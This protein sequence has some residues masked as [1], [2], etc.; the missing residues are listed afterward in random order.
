VLS[1]TATGTDGDG[2]TQGNE[3]NQDSWLGSACVGRP[4][5]STVKLHRPDYV[6]GSPF[7]NVT[8]RVKNL[9]TGHIDREGN[10][11]VEFEIQKV[12]LRMSIDVLL[13]LSLLVAAACFFLARQISGSVL[14]H[15]PTSHE[16][17]SCIPTPRPA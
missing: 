6:V 15:I 16:L 8:R 10:R 7:W 11:P 2:T 4:D 12:T 3:K 9:V 17:H 5:G 13:I 14:Q 1:P